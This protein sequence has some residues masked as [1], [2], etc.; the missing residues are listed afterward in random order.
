MHWKTISSCCEFYQKLAFATPEQGVS[1][2]SSSVKFSNIECMWTKIKT[3]NVFLLH[4]IHDW[5]ET[6]KLLMLWTSPI[7]ITFLWMY[8]TFI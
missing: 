5:S 6:E 8:I 3:G 2:N 7:L 4:S 1:F